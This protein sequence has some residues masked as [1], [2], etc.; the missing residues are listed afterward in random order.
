MLA[1]NNKLG[2]EA[3][4]QYTLYAL[5]MT[6]MTIIVYTQLYPILKQFIDGAIPEMDEATA[7]LM[8]LTP[9]VILFFIIYGAM[10]YVIPQREKY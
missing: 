6:V 4:G 7:T 8:S 1:K 9:L 2:G 5:F 3:K 10:W